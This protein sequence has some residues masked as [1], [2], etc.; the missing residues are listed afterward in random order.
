MGGRI[1]NTSHV[2]GLISGLFLTSVWSAFGNHKIFQQ[3]I[4]GLAALLVVLVLVG[5]AFQMP[6]WISVFLLAFG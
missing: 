5:Y 2:A 4:K 1:D 6:Y 3:L